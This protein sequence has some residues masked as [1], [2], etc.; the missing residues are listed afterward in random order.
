MK[1][2]RRRSWY[3][4][5]GILASALWFFCSAVTVIPGSPAESYR[6]ALEYVFLFLAGAAFG[7][8]AVVRAD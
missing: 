6:W 4:V 3:V 5:A 1:P 2:S 8:A 7:A